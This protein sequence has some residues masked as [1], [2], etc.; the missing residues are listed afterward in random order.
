ML[1]QDKV[2]IVS[3]IGPGMGRDISLRFAGGGREARARGAH[4]IAHRGGGARGRGARRR[5]RPG[6]HRHHVRRGCA[7]AGRRG[8]RRVRPHRRAGQQRLPHRHDDALRARRSRRRLSRHGRR[9]PV[10]DAARDAGG[11]PGDE[12]PR[13]RLDRDDQ[14]DEH[15]DGL[16]RLHRVRG[17]E[18]GAP[19]RHA[20]H[21]RRARRVRPFASTPCCPGTS[22]ARRS[23]ASSRPGPRRRGRTPQDVYDEVAS[24]IALRRI[25]DSREI[26]GSVVFFASDLASC[27]TG[28]SLDVNG[29]MVMV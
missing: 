23:R 11:R 20:R 9:E 22:G 12:G 19:G 27:I 10:R 14:H 15:P 18:G 17:L 4:G 28:A 1:L 5:S 29:G 25:P 21:G 24:Q 6:A 8:G 16:A 7:A 13:R 26:S 2:A 3:G